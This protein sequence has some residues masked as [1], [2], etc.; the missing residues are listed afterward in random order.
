MVK[1]KGL[2]AIWLTIVVALML[3]MIPVP[4]IVSQVWP[5]WAVLVVC[6]WVIAFPSQVNVFSAFVVGLLLDVIQ[7]GLFGEH[8]FSLLVLAII[9]SAF[10]LRFRMFSF[11][12]QA[13]V[14]FCLLMLY[15][16]TIFVIQSS[17]GS[18]PQGLF[19]WLAPVASMILWPL[20]FIV[21]RDCRRRFVAIEVAP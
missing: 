16:V 20:V 3:T 11:L 15:Q 5:A 13:L 18:A 1:P 8:A 14:M 6:Y 2:I 4:G 7:G 9:L 21:L 12:Q 17:I 19:Y 10:H